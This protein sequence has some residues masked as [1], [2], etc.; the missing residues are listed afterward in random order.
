MPILNK[1]INLLALCCL[2]L[3]ASYSAQASDKDDYLHMMRKAMNGGDFQQAALNGIEA[4]R[5]YSEQGLTKEHT[6]AVILLSEAYQSLGQY[7]KALAELKAAAGL[8]ADGEDLA[9]RAV[10]IGKLGNAYILVNM[11]DEAEAT[12]TGAVD[13]AG[14]AKDPLVTASVLNTLGNLYSIRGRNNDAVRTYGTALDSLK[15]NDNPRLAGTINLNM[16]G[17]LVKLG[18]YA[19]QEGFLNAA[20]ALL[21]RLEASHDQAYGYINA[22]ELYEK[23]ALVATEDKAARIKQALNAFAE[24]LKAAITV[25]DHAA[26]SYA[27]GGLG[28]LA[29]TRGRTE[30]ALSLTRRALFEAQAVGAPEA[31]YLWQWQS[32]RLLLKA[33]DYM[34]ALA[35]FR[36]SVNTLQSIRREF[37]GDCKIYNRLSFQDSVE[38]VYLGLADILLRLYDSASDKARAEAYLVETVRTVELLK[39]AEL[40]DYFYN[41]C[42]V[43]ERKEIAKKDIINENTAVVYYVMLPDRL[44]IIVG[45]PGGIKKFRSPIGKKELTAEVRQFRRM[46]EK[47]TTREYLLYARSLYSKLILPFEGEL[48]SG[49]F[50]T[51]VFV[52]EGPLRTIPL[53]VLH[54]GQNFLIK[55]FA[56][57][58]IPALSF[59]VPHHFGTDKADVLLA[60]L[61]ESVQGFDPLVY[62]LSEIS[63]IRD[64]YQKNNLLLNGDFLVPSLREAL[65]KRPYSI[66]HIASHGVF[67]G[68]AD[69]T[70]ILTW[71]GKLTMD[72]IERFI[73]MNRFRK[74]S[75][76]LLTLSACKTAVSSDRAALG[77]AGLAVKAGAKS[78]LA[79]LWYINDKA[80][81]ELMA[82]FYRLLRN[83]KLSYAKALQL[84]QLT[85]QQNFRYRHPSYWSPFLLIGNWM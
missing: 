41:S 21:G 60:A 76:E 78:A 68:N 79:T 66:V 81:S 23:L 31:L 9:L 50:D 83:D 36:A 28:R 4:V 3:V 34:A 18:R 2:C 27:L 51:I 10:V 44:E 57:A 46:L 22:A 7:R 29:E 33:R 17:T 53:S 16:A 32:G 67:S 19:E 84:A 5:F 52:P 20:Y 59:T 35:S 56:V 85:L 30:E 11:L 64:L 82:K 47:R 40:Q 42:F 12:L 1:I 15:D 63:T 55:R 48:S 25:G 54:D 69:E 74:N 43:A 77:L 62:V 14:K 8:T 71:D 58:E 26:Q 65:W 45:T 49:R 37:S 61:S 73:T 39:S 24:A 13:V 70:Y 38:P 80:S 72:H 75:V 6:K